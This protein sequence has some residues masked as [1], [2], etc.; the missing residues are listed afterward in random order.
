M[1]NNNVVDSRA[2]VTSPLVVALVGERRKELTDQIPMRPVQ[3][4]GVKTDR[5]GT[6]GS[7]GK[8]VDQVLSQTIKKGQING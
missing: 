5:L 8:L 4:N 3:L 6:L 1:G 7:H 2:R